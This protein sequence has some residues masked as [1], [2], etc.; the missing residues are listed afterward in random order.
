MLLGFDEGD[1]FAKD[2]GGIIT[3]GWRAPRVKS[4]PAKPGAY[5]FVVIKYR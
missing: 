2:K 5:L 1:P 4:F 3:L